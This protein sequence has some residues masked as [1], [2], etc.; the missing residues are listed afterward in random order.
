MN[1]SIT[2]Q[3]V[4][5]CSSPTQRSVGIEA[6]DD[7]FKH[8]VET[9]DIFL[10]STNPCKVKHRQTEPST[11]LNIDKQKCWQSE[12]W[13]NWNVGRPKLRHTEISTDLNVDTIKRRHSHIKTLTD[14]SVDT[15]KCLLYS[16]ICQLLCTACFVGYILYINSDVNKDRLRYSWGVWHTYPHQ[17]PWRNSWD[18]MYIPVPKVLYVSIHALCIILGVYSIYHYPYTWHSYTIQF[19]SF[20]RC[21][22][23]VLTHIICIVGG[24]RCILCWISAIIW[25]KWTLYRS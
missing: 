3:K 2:G 8:L 24:M 22:V 16:F 5:L 6:A 12:T 19:V 18:A 21:T 1:M 9:T 15:P 10:I 4:A 25:I 20:V 17:N 7:N 11:N 13:T 23:C 14:Q